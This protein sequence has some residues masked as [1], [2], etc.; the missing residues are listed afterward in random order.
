MRIVE[1]IER[2]KLAHKILREI[3][4]TISNVIA[5]DNQ[6]AAEITYTISK[7]L[8]RI[9]EVANE[10]ERSFEQAESIRRDI[11]NLFPR[12]DKL[13]IQ[14]TELYHL[15][16]EE[17]SLAYRHAQKESAAYLNMSRDYS[18]RLSEVWEKEN[19]ISDF[20]DY[21]FT[22]CH[23]LTEKLRSRLLRS[24]SDFFILFRLQKSHLDRALSLTSELDSTFAIRS[25]GQRLTAEESAQ[26]N[27]ILATFKNKTE[28]IHHAFRSLERKANLMI[29]ERARWL[30]GNV[31]FPEWARIGVQY[32]LHVHITQSKHDDLAP[33]LKIS[34]SSPSV[35]VNIN[36]IVA[37]ITF[38]KYFCAI[39][40]YI[41]FYQDMT[42]IFHSYSII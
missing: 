5:L 41:I 32:S 18:D 12:I 35:A 27:L 3:N 19:Q 39:S 23:H 33:L 1:L 30:Y 26:N 11:A 17:F 4:R 42:R 20:L 10:L 34:F 28:T 8:E 31:S 16:S 38:N 37:C 40:E 2:L 6:H 24:G 15:G 22:N 13:N 25:V 14:A 9:Y 29:S 21:S 36:V 7:E